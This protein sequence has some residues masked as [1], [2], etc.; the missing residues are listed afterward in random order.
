MIKCSCVAQ[1][2]STIAKATAR[3]IPSPLVV[4]Q[5]AFIIIFAL[6][7]QVV[8][9]ENSIPYGFPCEEAHLCSNILLQLDGH[10]SFT[11]MICFDYRSYSVRIC[12]QHLGGSCAIMCQCFTRSSGASCWCS[13]GAVCVRSQ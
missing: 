9:S 11:F 2:I 12:Y 10:S 7:S 8:N 5:Q 4:K 3:K 1:S 13:L 6:P